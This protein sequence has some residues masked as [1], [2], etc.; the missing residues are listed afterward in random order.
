MFRSSKFW[1]PFV[2]SLLLN[3]PWVLFILAGMGTHEKSSADSQAMLMLV[4]PY[5]DII[6]WFSPSYALF[7]LFLQIPVY[8]F[9]VGC[10]WSNEKLKPTLILLLLAHA[11]AYLVASSFNSHF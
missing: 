3:V 2:L 1:I 6:M 11:L 5:I 4:F 8:G 7:C 10:G 9:L